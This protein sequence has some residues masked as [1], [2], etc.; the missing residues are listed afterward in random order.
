MR[1]PGDTAVC[2][3]C[4]TKNAEAESFLDSLNAIVEGED[5]TTVAESYRSI[6][7]GRPVELKEPAAFYTL[8]LSGTQGRIIVRDWFETSLQKAVECLTKHFIDLK[9]VR[10]ARPAKDKQPSPS[11]PL[12]WLMEALASEGRQDPVPGSLEAAI[13]RAALTGAA[14]PLQIL[15]RAL[16]RARVETGRDKWTDLARRDARAALLK[17]VLNRRR[18]LDPQTAARYEEVKPDM[19]PNY[20]NPGYALG[21]LMAVLERL[22]SAALGQV[23]TTLVDRYFSAASSTPRMIF[24]RLLRNAQHHARKARDS[25]DKRDRDVAFLCGRVIDWIADRFD[26][27]RK[28]YPPRINGLPPHL[29]LEEQGLFVLGYHQMRYWLWMSKEER[30]AW[31]QRYPDAPAALRWLKRPAEEQAQPEAAI[32]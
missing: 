16:L 31:E 17:A 25:D 32:S 28:C 3:W 29:D 4:T 11:V 27:D 13:F 20:D 2:F 21:A 19:N 10:H 22:Q 18:R 30:T 15:Q 26:V 24:V 12:R 8:V 23:N 9:I 14:Y 5:E 6:W 7:H 1:L